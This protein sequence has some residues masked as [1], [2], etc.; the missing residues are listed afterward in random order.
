MNDTVLFLST[1]LGLSIICNIILWFYNSRARTYYS[2]ENQKSQ[3]ELVMKMNEVAVRVEQQ[4]TIIDTLT[5]QIKK[6]IQAAGQLKV[7]QQ[8]LAD[9]TAEAEALKGQIAAAEAQAMQDEQLGDVSINH[10]VQATQ[11]LGVAVDG[12]N[13]ASSGQ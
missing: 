12:L 9:K 2:P 8:Q 1:G 7:V 6:L 10:L 5:E 11:G 13:V 3:K 4:A